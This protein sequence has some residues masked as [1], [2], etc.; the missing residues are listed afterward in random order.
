MGRCPQSPLPV[1]TFIL[2]WYQP[3]A[4]FLSFSLNLTLV[5][6]IQCGDLPEDNCLLMSLL[7]YDAIVFRGLMRLVRWL[8]IQWASAVAWHEWQYCTGR[9]RKDRIYQQQGAQPTMHCKHPTE[10]QSKQLKL[11]WK[12]IPK[13]ITQKEIWTWQEISL[14]F[15]LCTLLISNSPVIDCLCL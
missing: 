5:S 14:D 12:M 11:K 3:C 1:P 7:C 2:P 6:L 13:Q 8:K 15:V 9:S 4:S 10:T